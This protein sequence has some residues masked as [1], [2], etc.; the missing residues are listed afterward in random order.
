MFLPF[1]SL[2]SSVGHQD[3]ISQTVTP[4]VARCGLSDKMHLP[5]VGPWPRN[6]VNQL[7]S[8]TF[9]SSY[10][11]LSHNYHCYNF[12][13]SLSPCHQLRTQIQE[14]RLGPLNNKML[15]II[16]TRCFVITNYYNLPVKHIKT[17]Q[18][19][20]IYDSFCS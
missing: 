15:T 5:V 8:K 17:K 11:Y 7:L 20:L 4:A 10:F 2:S 16:Y 18:T 9:G 3:W 14:L 12:E 6:V 1:T 19:L 13:K